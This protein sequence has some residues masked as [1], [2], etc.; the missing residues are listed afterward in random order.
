MAVFTA[1]PDALI[2]Y[3]FKLWQI[4]PDNRDPFEITKVTTPVYE[5]DL[6]ET[7]LLYDGSLPPLEK[8]ARY[9]WQVTALDLSG[10]V[11]F[12]KDGNSDIATFRYGYECAAPSA[13]ISKVSHNSVSVSWNS[14]SSIREYIVSYRKEN[15]PEWQEVTTSNVG[16]TIDNLEHSVQYELYV[17]ASCG[18]AS[19]SNERLLRFKTDRFVDYSCG[20][21]APRISFENQDPLPALHRFDEFKAAD[22][23]IEVTEVSG[24]QGVFSG[25]GLASIPFL[26]FLKFEV[27]FNDITINTDRQMIDGHVVFLHEEETGKIPG[28]NMGVGGSQG[29]EGSQELSFEEA[30][31]EI[32]DQKVTIDEEVADVSVS[33]G[34]V[35]VVTESGQTQSYLVGENQTLAIVTPE[36]IVVVDQASGQVFQAPNTPPGSSSNVRTPSQSGI[37]GCLVTFRPSATQRLGFDAVGNDVVK[38]NSYF[39]RDRNGDAVPWKSLEAGNTDY[40]AM[41]TNGDCQA[42]SLRFIR[43]SGLLTP[44]TPGRN[45]SLELLLTG[46][47]QGQ[48]ERLT[49]ARATTNH[50]ND[51]T[52]EEI[53]TEAGVLGLV[54]YQRITR[55]VFLIPVNGASFPTA[56]T[57]LSDIEKRLNE[58]YGSAVIN[59]NVHFDEPI[60]VGRINEAD[61]KVEG[62]SMLSKYTSDMNRVIRTYKRNRPSDDN[63]LYLFFVELSDL[64]TSRKGFMPLAGNF[65]FIF[66]FSASDFDL[67]AHELA[68][69]AFNLRHTFSDKAQ[70]YFPV[71]QTANLMD[72]AGGTDLWKYQWDLIHNPEKI[73]F[74]WAQSEEEGAAIQSLAD[75]KYYNIKDYNWEHYAFLSPVGTAI[76]IKG[77]TDVLFNE[78]GAVLNFKK[79]GK[80]YYGVHS[81]ESQRFVGYLSQEDKDVLAKHS[82][83]TIEFEIEF[84]QKK[85]DGITYASKD[86]EVISYFKL[87]DGVNYLDCLRKA[88]WKNSTIPTSYTGIAKPPFIPSDAVVIDISGNQCVDYA[89][90]GVRN[91]VGKDIYINLINVITEEQKPL[92]VEL[93]N[94]FTDSVSNERFA[95]YGYGLEDSYSS[96]VFNEQVIL[97]LKNNKIYSKDLLKQKF[98]FI[99]TQ[100]RDFGYIFSNKDLWVDIPDG[101]NRNTEDYIR[102]G[103]YNYSLADLMA[104]EK[105]FVNDDIFKAAIKKMEQTGDAQPLAIH[106]NYRQYVEKWGTDAALF[107]WAEYAARTAKPVTEA[108]MA[109]R[110]MPQLLSQLGVNGFIDKVVRKFGQDAVTKFI[111]GV[112]IEAGVQ[113]IV[114]EYVVKAEIDWDNFSKDIIIA[115]FRN[116]FEFSRSTNAAID[117]LQGIQLNSIIDLLSA[118]N[119][120][121][122]VENTFVLVAECAIP[123][124]FSYVLGNRTHQLYQPIST[125]SITKLGRILSKYLPESAVGTII[126]STKKIDELAKH[127]SLHWRGRLKELLESEGGRSV[128]QE[129]SNAGF[130]ITTLSAN[131]LSRLKT[132][133]MMIGEENSVAFSRLFKKGVDINQMLIHLEKAGST[134]DSYMNFMDNV[135]KKGNFRANVSLSNSA[136][137]QTEF[138]INYTE[139]VIYYYKNEGNYGYFLKYEPNLKIASEIIVDIQSKVIISAQIK[140]LDKVASDYIKQ[141]THEE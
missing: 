102:G 138:I 54:S 68:H 41:L 18:D 60:E 52:S 1:I 141:L 79:N 112:I 34:N 92:L 107:A 17:R 24:S 4:R 74:S 88:V 13:V 28:R 8:G 83:L 95:F 98:P 129:L 94:Y 21:G 106:E 84:N 36:S 51:S 19:S 64:G 122:F 87:K 27:S 16:L 56:S 82:L 20:A 48:E 109:Y 89:A 130:D 75:R 126:Y 46:G 111:E 40:V 108:Y 22:F 131:N 123:A 53:L 135:I 134:V 140:E 9:V 101:Y 72:Y 50:I 91:G 62:T 136:I 76:N 97:Y 110:M 114:A 7:A 67:L 99:V 118:N 15:D 44:T 5:V 61:F 115:G 85:Y 113:V 23:Y 25:R 30:L 116:I 93:A 119:R 96:G 31:K 58:I 66:N 104:R 127:R 37:H 12:K 59:W 26:E 45:N 71:Q 69:G 39:L 70:H 6:S 42:D 2:E 49:V 80:I 137:T 63:S 55:D 120:Q 77:A 139:G 81:V 10:N 73:L 3:R 78:D 11:L 47:F 125:S 86:Q 105:F 128:F 57:Q 43:E 117:C 29:A 124:A 90:E 32:A 103:K 65:G 14:N 132:V 121:D 35:T 133:A 100:A 38:P 33:N